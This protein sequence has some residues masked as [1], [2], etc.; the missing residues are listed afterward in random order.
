MLPLLDFPYW[1]KVSVLPLSGPDGGAD[2]E[3]Q[4]EAAQQGQG[5]DQCEEREHPGRQL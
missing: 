4:R 2:R 5:G 1:S 3:V